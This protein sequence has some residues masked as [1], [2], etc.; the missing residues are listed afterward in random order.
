[1]SPGVAALAVGAI[2]AAA[3][4]GN[5]ARHNIPVTR[6]AKYAALALVGGF[7]VT[8]IAYRFVP[9]LWL[10]ISAAP[11]AGAWWLSQRFGARN[12]HRS[13]HQQLLVARLKD[14][15]PEWT[16]RSILIHWG[17]GADPADIEEIKIGLP[18]KV[19]PTKVIAGTVGRAGIKSVVSETVGGQWTASTQKTI[20]TLRRAAPVIDPKP[21]RTAQRGVVGHQLLRIGS[22]AQE[23]VTSPSPATM[24]SRT[25][26]WPTAKAMRS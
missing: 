18:A 2:G 22:S 26:A 19:L 12:Y 3:V 4:L 8:A 10:V 15:I 25:T 20:V 17:A 9:V 14:V 5:A 13:G 7:I 11:A 6:F 24:R 16:G 1:M 21:I 23:L